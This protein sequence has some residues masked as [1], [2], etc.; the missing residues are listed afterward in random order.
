M[1]CVGS[2]LVTVWGAKGVQTFLCSFCT[3]VKIHA[4]SLYKSLHAPGFCSGRLLY[5]GFDL[6]LSKEGSWLFG[7]FKFHFMQLFAISERFFIGKHY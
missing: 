6:V 3:V 4:R 2:G 7:D 5:M 1:T